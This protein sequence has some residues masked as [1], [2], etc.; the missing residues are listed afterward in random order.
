[1]RWIQVVLCGSAFGFL[2]AGSARADEAGVAFVAGTPVE[3]T[4]DGYAQGGRLLLPETLETALRYEVAASQ[5]EME[6]ALDKRT[7]SHWC[8]GFSIPLLVGGLVNLLVAASG[9]VGSQEGTMAVYGVAG[10]LSA[11]AA[12]LAIASLVLSGQSD[13]HYQAAVDAY[14]ASLATSAFLQLVPLPSGGGAML[15][16]RF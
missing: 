6:L 4:P 2:W 10:G 11:A 5:A 7:A 15:T 16:L 13:E 8:L 9:T 12:A 1:M 3:A 14:N